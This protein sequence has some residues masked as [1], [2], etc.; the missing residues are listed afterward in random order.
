MFS[1]AA[2]KAFPVIDKNVFFMAAVVSGS[3]KIVKGK[4]DGLIEKFHG[5]SL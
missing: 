4:M 2:F 3:K 1:D 5:S